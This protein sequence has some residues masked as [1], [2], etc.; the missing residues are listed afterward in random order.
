[1]IEECKAR[2]DT[3]NMLR[4]IEEIH[5]LLRAHTSTR[6]SSNALELLLR[7]LYF[8]ILFLIFLGI[9]DFVVNFPSCSCGEPRIV[10]VTVPIY[11]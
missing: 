5:I 4:H 7:K 10:Y 6:T 2:D 9:L 3:E 1:M 11:R 8:M